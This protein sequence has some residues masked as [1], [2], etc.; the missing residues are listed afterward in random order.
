M[1]FQLHIHG[2]MNISMPVSGFQCKLDTQYRQAVGQTD[3]Q[4]ASQ[5]TVH[6]TLDYDTL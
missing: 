3:R 4:T 5:P 2:R 1:D 6:T